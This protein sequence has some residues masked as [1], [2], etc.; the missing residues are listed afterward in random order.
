MELAITKQD[1]DKAI[2]AAREAKG[3]VFNA[4]E[5]FIQTELQYLEDRYLGESGAQAV[6]N[7]ADSI[8][9]NIVKYLACIR[10]FLSQ[11]RGLD[12]VLTDTGFGVVSTN[13]TAP[14][15]KQRVD[16]LDGQLRRQERLLLGSLLNQLFNVSGWSNTPQC[17]FAVQTLFFCIQ[18]LEQWAGINNPKPEDWDTAVPTILEA[19]SFLRKHL[20][21]A[22]MD[23]LIEKMTSR[24]LDNY[25][26][27]IV[28]L[29]QQ[30]IG[31]CIAQNIRLREETY[32][33]LINH[34]EADLTHYPTYANG[35]GYRL[36]H[37]KPYENHAD[38]SAFHFVG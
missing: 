17:G 25:S 10:A 24:Q 34:L 18:Q 4:V 22:Y 3:H 19:D 1:F 29:C 37:F 13:S 14:A 7:D 16:A 11:L 31:A 21:N 27:P 33:R 38:D 35:E 8:L 12:L 28:H 23:E 15:S 2:P 30:Y 32:M 26:A 20:G 5:P 9:A 6:T 36:N